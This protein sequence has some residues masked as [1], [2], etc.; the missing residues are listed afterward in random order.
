MHAWYEPFMLGKLAL[1]LG[2][3]PGP[4]LEL[5]REAAAVAAKPPQRDYAAHR[6]HAVRAKYALSLTPE[7]IAQGGGTKVSSPLRF[8]S[9]GSPI[10]RPGAEPEG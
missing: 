3:P 5:F 10:S 8:A 2:N 7:L 4:A 6:I 9:I 1:K